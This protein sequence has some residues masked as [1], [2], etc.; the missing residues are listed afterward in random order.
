M[1]ARI[2]FSI[3]LALSTGAQAPQ[4]P[5]VPW[6]GTWKL[7]PSRST[8]VPDRYKRVMTR[9]E[10]SGDGLKV[11]YEM[12]GIRGGVSHLEWTGKFDGKDYPVEG[13]DSVLTNA[14]TLL[15]DRS[16]RIVVKVEGVLAETAVV[17]VSPDG[18][19]LTSTTTRRGGAT[20]LS[21]YEKQ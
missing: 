6:F 20:T 16:Y 2:I 9:I 15:G 1:A 5:Q 13:I 14:Y 3:L 4:A 17:E 21:V 18:K 8:A 12:I 10:P 19:T 11:T 7:D